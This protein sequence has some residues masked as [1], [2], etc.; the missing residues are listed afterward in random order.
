MSKN[1]QAAFPGVHVCCVVGQ[2]VHV[3]RHLNGRWH[4][5]VGLHTDMRVETK[6][7]NQIGFP[8]FKERA[9]ASSNQ[10]ECTYPRCLLAEGQRIVTCTAH[11][12]THTH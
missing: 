12:G 10:T 11:L 9:I 8:S 1:L 5:C 2:C 3:W 7:P 4:K 6:I